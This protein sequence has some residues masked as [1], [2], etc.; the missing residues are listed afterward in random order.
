MGLIM[1]L[2]KRLLLKLLTWKNREYI[3]L[4]ISY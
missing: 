4:I 3:A 2:T 1:S